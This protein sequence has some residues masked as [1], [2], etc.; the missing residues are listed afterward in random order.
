MNRKYVPQH[1]RCDVDIKAVLPTPRF[2]PREDRLPCRGSHRPA[3]IRQPQCRRFEGQTG[4]I[5]HEQAPSFGRK[6]PIA[7]AP[8]LAIAIRDKCEVPRPALDHDWLTDVVPAAMFAPASNDL[9]A[10]DPNILIDAAQKAARNA[11]LSSLATFAYRRRQFEWTRAVGAE[12][13]IVV[14]RQVSRKQTG[15]LFKT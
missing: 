10:L 4:G 6:K 11:D 3:V 13:R 8:G 15:C 14:P 9:G 2:G 1:V 7:A 12:S 5:H